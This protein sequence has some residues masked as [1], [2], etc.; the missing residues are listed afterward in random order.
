MPL[1]DRILLAGAATLFLTGG[2]WYQALGNPR[3]IWPLALLTLVVAV[4]AAVIAWK[5]KPENFDR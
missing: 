5:I 2:L 4:V 1:R 3:L